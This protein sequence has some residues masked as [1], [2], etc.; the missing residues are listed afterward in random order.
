MPAF[1]SRNLLFTKQM[2]EYIIKTP[3][4]KGVKHIE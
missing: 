3:K 1:F 4:K 2:F